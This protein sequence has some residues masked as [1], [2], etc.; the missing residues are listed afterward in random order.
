[1]ALAVETVITPRML[2]GGYESKGVLGS[3]E[4]D[5]LTEQGALQDAQLIEMMFDATT[6]R[7]G[8]LFDLRTAFQ[9]RM[10]NTGLLICEYVEQMNW[11]GQRRPAPRV[12]WPVDDSIPD[13]RDGRFRVR[14]LF[15]EGGHAEV[16][17]HG[18]SFYSGDIPD[19]PETPPDYMTGSEESITSGTAS[20][21]SP[22]NPVQRTVVE[23]VTG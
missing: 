16:T 2:V 8:W 12:A 23:P 21:N 3:P 18:A 14:I 7:L 1:M 10:A 11:S 13:N 4:M 5:P 19:L 20:M 15:Y 22:F 6:R 17:A 9:L